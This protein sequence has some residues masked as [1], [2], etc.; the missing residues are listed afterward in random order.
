MSS[1]PQ[2]FAGLQRTP[3][4]QGDKVS[5]QWQQGFNAL[6]QS[7][8]SPA[9]SAEVPASATAQGNPGQIA[10]DGAFLYI[11]FAQSQWVR[12]PLTTW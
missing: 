6:A 1:T 11:C 10:T 7:A 9:T 4:L 5:W 12:V 8:A 3:L 2:I